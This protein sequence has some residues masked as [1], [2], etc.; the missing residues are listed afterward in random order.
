MLDLTAL[1]KTLA[2]AGGSDLHLTAGSPPLIRVDGELL[3][4]ILGS[5]SC[6]TVL[7]GQL[8]GQ[9]S[10]Q[11]F[12]FLGAGFGLASGAWSHSRAPGPPRRQMLPSAWTPPIGLAAER[13]P[14][15]CA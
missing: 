5:F 6:L 14:Q 9:G 8:T 4:L 15:V 12:G 7:A 2:E 11:G 13:R 3:P 1:L 10:V